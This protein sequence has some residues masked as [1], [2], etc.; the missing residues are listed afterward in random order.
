MAR[1]ARLYG[2][3]QPARGL[4]SCAMKLP[5]IRPA[6]ATL[7]PLVTGVALGAAA[8]CVSP[9][10]AAAAPR[11]AVRTAGIQ[12][13]QAS[14]DGGYEPLIATFRR[15]RCRR[16]GDGFVVDARSPARGFEFS[17]QIPRWRG[18]AATYL[19]TRR[20]DQLGVQ[21]LVEAPGG[22]VYDSSVTVPGFPGAGGIAFARD[23]SA[24]SVGGTFFEQGNMNR[25]VTVAGAM[26]CTKPKKRR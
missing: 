11:A 23:G 13:R 19:L 10:A 21:V 8:V 5:K 26:T 3:P 17:V 16:Q 24:I 18:Y 14:N 1:K 22:H 7:V 15:A 4:L 6:P 12:I 25:G 20:V 9:A 2:R